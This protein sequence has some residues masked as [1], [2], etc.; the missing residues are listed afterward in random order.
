M[1][2]W[3]WFVTGI[4]TSFHCIAMCGTMV[5]SYAIRGSGD[6]TR[7]QAVR[8][9]LA[10]HAFKLL[11]YAT[12]GAIMGFIGSVFNFGRL[13]G[14]VNLVAGTFMIIMAINMLNLVPW[15]RFM[16]LR[17]P[18]G[19]S[20]RLFKG[21]APHAET[22]EK[23]GGSGLGAPIFMGSLTGLMP[24]GPLQAM[25]L[26]AAGT[27]SAVKGAFAMTVFGLGTIPLML[28]FGTFTSLIGHGLKKRV[29]KLSAV[30]VL[31]LGLVMLDRGLVLQGIPYNLTNAQLIAKESLG[32][33]TGGTLGQS[34]VKGK[35]QFAT[36]EMQGET[37]APNTLVV[38]PGIPLE[39][40]LVRKD[41]NPCSKQIVFPSMNILKDIPDNGTV[42]LKLDPKGEGN[43]NFTCGMGMMQGLLVVAQ[44]GSALARNAG[45]AGASVASTKGPDPNFVLFVVMMGVAG[46]MLYLNRNRE[47]AQKM[48][49]E[50][51][52]AEK[53]AALGLPVETAA[54]GAVAGAGRPAVGSRAGPGRAS[55]RPEAPK[56]LIDIKG[57]KLTHS[58]VIWA[59]IVL[60][61]AVMVGYYLSSSLSAN[62]SAAGILGG[63]PNGSLT[64]SGKTTATLSQGGL[65]QTAD[66]RVQG[67]YY[68]AVIEAK[69]GVKLRLRVQRTDRNVCSKYLV[70]DRFS[71]YEELPDDGQNVVE[72]VPDRAGEFLITC[73]MNMLVGK[74]VVN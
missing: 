72:F 51:A 15:F 39:L 74:L 44:P 14:V 8:P 32:M 19:L 36:I 10:Y 53:M 23:E 3:V 43:F 55:H 56:F 52:M 73:Q 7:W 50:A 34:K 47:I 12:I 5:L 49:A 25:E 18:K 65:V 28:G 40:K 22:E 57:F 60:V 37:Y 63:I 1:N 70:I 58:E 17:M 54:A 48:I 35:Q 33:S 24:C 61:L 66:L 27:G 26:F 29:M 13:A 38:T 9:H 31:V 45:A 69:K 20:R 68:P 21:R 59:A 42:T 41:A 6:E 16:N 71:V 2:I 11:S 30:V 46:L 4:L 62:L 67:G 64:G